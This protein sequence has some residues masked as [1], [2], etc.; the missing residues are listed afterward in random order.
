MR[1]AGHASIHP[2]KTSRG[3]HPDMK[4]FISYLLMIL[5]FTAAGTTE[6]ADRYEPAHQKQ[7]EFFAV[8]QDGTDTVLTRAYLE[9]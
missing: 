9:Q 1:A 5:L 8:Q 2:E 4:L 3:I 7:T 6:S